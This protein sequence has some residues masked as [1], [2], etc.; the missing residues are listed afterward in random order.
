MIF[1]AQLFHG[2]FA[3]S[4]DQLT[5]CNKLFQVLLIGQTIF[6]KAFVDFSFFFCN[7][8]CATEGDFA[9][10]FTYAWIQPLHST[11]K[12]DYI[13]QVELAI[14][15]FRKCSA[16]LWK[17]NLLCNSQKYWRQKRQNPITIAPSI[18]LTKLKGWHFCHLFH[19]FSELGPKKQWLFLNLSKTAVHYHHLLVARKLK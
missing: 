1:K 6:L 17:R 12:I 16:V 14:F 2:R 4:E 11:I 5:T 13:G 9:F 3:L 15:S 10:S 8:T 18:N 19:M 7:A